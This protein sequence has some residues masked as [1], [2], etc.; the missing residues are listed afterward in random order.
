[1]DWHEVEAKLKERALEVAQ[2]LLPQGKREG[3]EWVCGNLD[4]QPGRSL[5][6]NVTGKVGV[7]Y[8]PDQKVFD[9]LPGTNYNVYVYGELG[10]AIPGLPLSFHSHV[11]HT[12]GGFDYTKDYIDYTVG[13]SYKWKSLTF[14]ISGVGTNVSHSDARNNPF[15]DQT[16]TL[17][18]FQTYRAS[19]AVVVGSVSASF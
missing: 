9:F 13:V 2:H 17:S 8:A 4:G 16:G 18:P 10:F 12:G 6:V 7:N 11:G 5:K 14:D 1:M 3:G 19:K 15:P